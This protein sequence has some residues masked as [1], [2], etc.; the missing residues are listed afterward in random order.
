[1]AQS[2]PGISRS[3]HQFQNA[4]WLAMDSIR[5][6]KL[7]SFL[8]L[9]GVIIGVASV[10]MVG[11]AIAGLGVYADEST[12]KAFG[13]E[14]FLVAQIAAT[15]RLS[16]REYFDKVKRNKP[17]RTEDYR[18]V[19][20]VNGDS[21]LYSP[22]R[23]HVSDVKR[24]NL[25]CEDTTMLGVAADMASIRDIGV[26]DG[27]FFTDQE[28]HS[29]AFVAVIGDTVRTTLFPGDASPL[30]QIVRIEGIE[31]TVI[32]VQERLG[33]AFGRDQDKSIYIPITAFN[34]MYGPGTGFALFG[35]PKPASGL[36]LNGALDETRVALRT[37]FHARPGQEDNFDTLTPDAI[38]GFIDQLLS[39]VAAVVVPVTCISLVVGGIVIMN[40][41]LVSV[42]ERTRE[43]GIRKAVGGRRSDIM[44]QILIEAVVLATM[45]G[46]CGVGLGA[47]ATMA[48]GRVFDLSLHITLDYVMLSLAVSSIVGIASG[49]YPAA[50][51][52]KLDPVVA[53]R[54]E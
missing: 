51:A 4:F 54:A 11:A 17:I 26:V 35:R 13:S 1:M 52:A 7:R 23:N 6:H 14:S 40:I 31:F 12:A 27:R 45:G 2:G 25:I 16:R 36:T 53:L 22:Y 9:L 8:T 5:A 48:L 34:R 19:E 47:L 20:A 43:I 33:S 10:I 15:G 30:N 29:R 41:M 32:G 50:R 37:R 42:T 18:F 24:E 44:L 21:V 28:E 49:W 39:M 3:W 38:R 46:A